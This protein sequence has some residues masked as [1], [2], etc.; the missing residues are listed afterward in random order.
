[1]TAGPRI[2]SYEWSGG[3]EALLRFGP[4]D[5][6]VVV[7]A[8]PLFEEA[9]RTRAFGVSLLRGLAARGIGGV[10]PELPGQGESE[11]ATERATLPDLRSA[12]SAAPG[13]F[14]VSIRS[15]ALVAG[16]ARP[17]W[18][19][20][21]Q[22]GADLVRE[23]ARVSGGPL[24]GEKIE[25]AGNLLSRELM[26]A[27]RVQ[28]PPGEG[29]GSAAGCTEDKVAPQASPPPGPGLRRI[30]ALRSRVVRLTG[31]AGVADVHVDGPPL[32]R[33]AEPDNDLT[34]VQR[35]ATDIAYWMRACEG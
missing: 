34:L 27:L 14:V 26:E 10:L 11:V 23:L 2:D 12:F 20:T 19:L 7:L 6:P 4:D 13:R 21:P 22:S 35:L 33:R 15:G 30:G 31:D 8:L 32:W 25:V 24:D 5:G 29:W 16:D 28:R 18:S 17:C 3:R 1:M 9:N